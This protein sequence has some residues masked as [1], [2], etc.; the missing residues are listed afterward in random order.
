MKRGR[1]A[2]TIQPTEANRSGGED[3]HI[4]YT[5]GE[6]RGMGRCI[7]VCVCVCASLC[8][9]KTEPALDPVENSGNMPA[10]IYL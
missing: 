5:C 2:P 4:P 8:V 1:G 6:C 9:L 3:M 10:L 7:C